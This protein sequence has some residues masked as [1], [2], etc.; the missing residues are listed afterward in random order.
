MK[1]SDAYEQWR[2]TRGEESP[3]DEFSDRVMAAVDQ[4]DARRQT[5]DARRFVLVAWL[6]RRRRGLLFLAGGAAF[7]LRMAAAISFFVAS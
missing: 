4:A 1:T 7:V 2:R 5:E 6:A 3:S